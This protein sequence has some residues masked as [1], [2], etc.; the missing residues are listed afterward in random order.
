MSAV[1]GTKSWLA[2]QQSELA[3]FELANGT[4]PATSG[5]ES[6]SAEQLTLELK[7]TQ[8]RINDIKKTLKHK[9]PLLY[10]QLSI[11]E[12]EQLCHG[13]CK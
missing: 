11:C 6:T 3:Q 2:A 8:Q 9:Y 1:V 7:R 12:C 10:A 5:A 4:A 13:C